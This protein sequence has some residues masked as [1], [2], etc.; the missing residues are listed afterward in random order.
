MNENV[1]FLSKVT[2]LLRVDVFHLSEV[3]DFCSVEKTIQFMCVWTWNQCKF[4]HLKIIVIKYYSFHNK[5]TH[6]LS[7]PF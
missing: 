4:S 3:I 5:T 2:P 7:N 1:Y 6:F